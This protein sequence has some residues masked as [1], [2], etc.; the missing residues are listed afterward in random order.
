MLFDPD[1]HPNIILKSNTLICSIV[2]KYNFTPDNMTHKLAMVPNQESV[3]S[4][5]HIKISHNE[6]KTIS[7]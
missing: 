7:H 2:R 4:L 3:Y 1:K 6:S 5:Q